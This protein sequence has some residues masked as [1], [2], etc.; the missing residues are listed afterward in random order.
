M[1]ERISD[2]EDHIATIETM[3]GQLT[4][5]AAF[6]AQHL[7]DFA[8]RFDQLAKEV[9]WVRG[10]VDMLLPEKHHCPK[11]KAIVH[12]QATK[13]KCGHGWGPTSDPKGGLPQ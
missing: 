9:R 2:L 6:T 11:C 7:L 12:K 8:A 13:C 4:E 10:R 1:E 5:Q 3:L